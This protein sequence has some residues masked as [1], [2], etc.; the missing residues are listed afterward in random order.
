[1]ISTP[2]AMTASNGA[3]DA[4]DFALP[5]PVVA[6]LRS[7]RE[8]L[9]SR[10]VADGMSPPADDDD[11]WSWD[12][13]YILNEASAGGKAVGPLRDEAYCFTAI[14]SSQLPGT[15]C[16][17]TFSSLTPAALSAF[18][19]PATRASMIS[20]FHRACT[21]PMRR[22]EP[23]IR[24]HHPLVSTCSSQDSPCDRCPPRQASA[25]VGAHSPS[26]SFGWF[27]PAGAMTSQG[28]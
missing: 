3:V 24:D 16:T 12:A 7:V 10:S 19:V 22:L 15:F 4:P 18:L 28:A 17:T 2:M 21:M 13:A 20:L 9:E 11:D 6:W 23:T 1:L 14:G 26:Y 27:S 5:D 8:V 25:A